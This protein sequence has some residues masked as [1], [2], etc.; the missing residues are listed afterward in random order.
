MN[1]DPLARLTAALS[2]RYVIE[3]EPGAGGMATVYFAEDI[4]YQRQVAIKVFKP[5]LPAVVATRSTLHATR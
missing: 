3:R 2:N 5:D 4:K 1:Q